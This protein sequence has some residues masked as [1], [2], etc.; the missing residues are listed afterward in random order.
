MQTLI[1]FVWG[2]LVTLGIVAVI[3][4]LVGLVWHIWQH[5]HQ[6]VQPQPQ[7]PQQQTHPQYVEGLDRGGGIVIEAI[8]RALNRVQ[9]PKKIEMGSFIIDARN[10][11]TRVV[12]PH[13]KTEV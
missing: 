10:D 8:E 6:Q 4:L 5:Y 11:S 9:N 7:Q 13:I 2:I 12:G 1:S 3:G